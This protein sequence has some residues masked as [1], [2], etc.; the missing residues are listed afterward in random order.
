MAVIRWL[1]HSF[2]ILHQLLLNSNSF[3][4][5]RISLYLPVC[6]AI[7]NIVMSSAQSIIVDSIGTLRTLLSLWN[8]HGDYIRPASF[9]RSSNLLHI[10]AAKFYFTKLSTFYI[11]RIITAQCQHCPSQKPA[12]WRWLQTWL[13]RNRSVNL[14]IVRA[15][16]LKY[17]PQRTTAT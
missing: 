10:S 5:H 17:F 1:L 13:Y 12:W 2:I 3:L 11:K 8:N 4:S 14:L 16:S 6:F 7:T 15:Y 9:D